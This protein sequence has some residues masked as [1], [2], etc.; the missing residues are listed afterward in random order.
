MKIADA[1]IAM[2]GRHFA[3]ARTEEHETLRAWIGQRRPDFEGTQTA[4]RI[5]AATPPVQISAAAKSAQSAEV[6]AIRQ[7]ND[8]VERDPFLL[9]L[10]TM[11]EWMTGE[12]VKVFDATLL[13]TD[14]PPPPPAKSSS[15]E[16]APPTPARAGYGIEYDFHALHEEFEQTNFTA[17][18]TILTADGREIDFRLDLTMTRHYREETHVSLRAGDGVRK[19]PLV[20][21][22]AGTAAQ[23]SSQ[24]FKFDLDADGKAEDVPLLVGGSGYLAL[25]LDGNGRVD[26]G[27]ELFGPASGLG[28]AELAEHDEDGNGWIDESDDVFKRLLVWTPAADGVGTLAALAERNVGALHLGHAATPFEL[29]GQGNQ[30]LGAT[31]A[32]GIYLTESGEAGTLQEIDLTV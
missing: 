32:S 24:R 15:A 11:I 26:S 29:R 30:D 7:A 28:F 6:D 31:R 22:F 17:Q 1:A 9:L 18:G 2:Q 5:E 13:Q 20:I 21:N 23:L 12:P 3:A 25:D 14:T 16:A 19:D 10:K 4:P 8:A 27:A